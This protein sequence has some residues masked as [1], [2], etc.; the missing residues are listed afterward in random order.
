MRFSKRPTSDGRWQWNYLAPNL[1][2]LARSPTTYATEAE[3]DAA[4][5]HYIVQGHIPATPAQTY[6]SCFI[7]YSTHDTAFA[8]K[9][10]HRLQRDGVSE[11]FAPKDLL[12]G[13]NTRSALDEALG[14]K[15][16]TIVVFSKS[17]IVSHWV[18][19]EIEKAFELERTLNTTVLLPV[20]I[21]NAFI[22][23]TSGWAADIR[24]LRNVGDFTKWEEP[25]RFEQSS[26]NLLT[27][28][29]RASGDA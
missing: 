4:I 5:L 9:L 17:S 12:Y 26:R 20:T 7:S 16:R 19:K 28:I 8:E 15:D 1:Q 6:Q 3:C 14:S 10:H 21:D 25:E 13:A 24:R 18:E 27:A 23:T 11:W 2:I 29:R 22:S